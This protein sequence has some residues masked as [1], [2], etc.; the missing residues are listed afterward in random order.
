[1]QSLTVRVK[2]TRVI[3]VYFS[4]AEKW[5]SALDVVQR[6]ILAAEADPLGYRMGVGHWVINADVVNSK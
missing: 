5:A 6:E 4:E 2:I 3:D 1:M